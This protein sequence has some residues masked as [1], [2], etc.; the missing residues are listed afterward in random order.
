[1]SFFILIVVPSKERSPSVSEF[2]QQNTSLQIEGADVERKTSIIRNE[3]SRRSSHSFDHERRMSRVMEPQS[4]TQR[5]KS[6][7]RPAPTPS[8][9][10]STTASR[11][12]PPAPDGSIADSTITSSHF[13]AARRRTNQKMTSSSNDL[14]L[15]TPTTSANTRSKDGQFHTMPNM[16]KSRK[17]NKANV[18]YYLLC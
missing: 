8:P 6:L 4:T 11:K 14:N 15:T 7:E 17:L 18:S 1:M 13:S 2:I 9:T 12:T 5:S 3:F 10:Q 16:K